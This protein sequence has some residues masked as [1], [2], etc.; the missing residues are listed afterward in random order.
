[1][2][3]NTFKTQAAKDSETDE[4]YGK[5]MSL[6]VITWLA[7]PVLHVA[8]VFARP[9]LARRCAEAAKHHFTFFCPSPLS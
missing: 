3:W 4:V 9:A 8:P 6:T 5:L 7:Y 2:L 1:M